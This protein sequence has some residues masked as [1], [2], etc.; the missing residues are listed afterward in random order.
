[1]EILRTGV[2]GYGCAMEGRRFSE[3]YY[4]IIGAITLILCIM[5]AARGDYDVAAVLGVVAA[6]L[7]IAAVLD[8]S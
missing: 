5:R 3:R 6:V 1:V 2:R 4:A 8:R 7:F